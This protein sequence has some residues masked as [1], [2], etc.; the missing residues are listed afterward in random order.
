MQVKFS[1]IVTI[2]D[3]THSTKNRVLPSDCDCHISADGATT[4]TEEDDISFSCGDSSIPGSVSRMWLGPDGSNLGSLTI[5]TVVNLQRTQ[6]GECRCQ[7]INT[8][9]GSTMS[10][11]VTI[12]FTC[13]RVCM[14][15]L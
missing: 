10:T 5:L 2:L 1:L 15:I 11:S 13:K 8:M 7:L 4:I 14:Y 12:T 3:M 9:D 6:S